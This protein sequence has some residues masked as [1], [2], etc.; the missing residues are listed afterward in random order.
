MRSSAPIWISL[1][2]ATH[3]AQGLTCKYSYLRTQTVQAEAQRDVAKKSKG[4]ISELD[5]TDV[6]LLLDF[7][8]LFITPSWIPIGKMTKG[9]NG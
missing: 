4:Q 6:D 3:L 5:S 2:R 9:K 7:K 8:N 1:T